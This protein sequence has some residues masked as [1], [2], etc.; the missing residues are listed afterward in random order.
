MKTNL[1]SG[2]ETHIDCSGT[3]GF[4][5]P[6][7]LAAV[8]PTDRSDTIRTDDTALDRIQ[9]DSRYDETTQEITMYSLFNYTPSIEHENYYV[10]CIAIQSGFQDGQVMD[11]YPMQVV[12]QQYEVIYAPKVLNTKL[13]FGF[14]PENPG[15]VTF[16]LKSNPKPTN[17]QVRI[18]GPKI[19][20]RYLALWQFF[21]FF[22]KNYPLL[23]KNV[24]FPDRLALCT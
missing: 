11:I 23:L 17:E 19:Q 2:K 22:S 16:T 6:N 14:E 10:K 7:L 5:Q 13:N 21:F 4:P 8:G 18:F 3:G 20:S 9:Q 15:I 1:F 12:S 24:V